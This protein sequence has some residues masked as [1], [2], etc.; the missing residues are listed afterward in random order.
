VTSTPPA[1][2]DRRTH[3][4]PRSDTAQQTPVD[5]FDEF[6]RSDARARAFDAFRHGSPMPPHLFVSLLLRGIFVEPLVL[7]IRYFP[8]PIGLLLRRWMG[9]IVFKKLGRNSLI[10]F[11]VFV[12]GAK[13]VSI[14]DYVWVDRHVEL[15]TRTGRIVIGKRVHIAPYAMISGHGGVEIG[16]YVGISADVKIYSHS[17]IPRDGKRMSG[18]MIPEN[19]K[20]MLTRPVQIKKDAF[21]GTG[22]VILPGVTIG[23]GAVVAA[24]SLVRK[25]VAPWTIVMGVPAK[26]VGK[27][28]RVTVSD[29]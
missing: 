19:M 10:D 26:T 7:L 25:D 2:P 1:T 16:D 6:L 13:N 4:A 17:E 24:N 23:E 28:S 14:G 21:I 20:G 8:N 12:E 5:E 3:A 27:R 18:P 22:A 9:K 11:G 15:R 29:I